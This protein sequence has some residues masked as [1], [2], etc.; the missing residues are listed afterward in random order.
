MDCLPFVTTSK[1][2]LDFTKIIHALVSNFLRILFLLFFH[3]FLKKNRKLTQSTEKRKALGMEGLIT[4]LHIHLHFV[5]WQRQQRILELIVFWVKEVLVESTKGA[6]RVLIRYFFAAR[7][8]FLLGS[9]VSM[10]II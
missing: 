3:L 6:W 1:S 2:R 5:N 8:I 7:I 10:L 9:M 4:L